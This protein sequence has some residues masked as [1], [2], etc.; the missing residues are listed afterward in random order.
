MEACETRSHSF[1]SFF[2]TGND[3]GKDN[4]GDNTSQRWEL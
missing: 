4:V 3:C 2:K 1:F